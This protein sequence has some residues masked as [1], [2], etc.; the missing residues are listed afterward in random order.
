MAVKEILLLGNP[1]L[2]SKCETVKKMDH[3]VQSTLNDLKD[4]LNDFRSTHNFG[5]GIAALQIGLTKKIVFLQIDQPLVLINPEITGRSRQKMTLW[6]D[7]FSFPEI[8]V[9]VKRHTKITVK[10]TDEHGRRKILHAVGG[11]SELLQHEIDHL[12][13]ILAIDRAI[14]SKHIILKN[15]WKKLTHT[16]QDTFQL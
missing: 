1:I 8:V 7:C 6:D 10:Y 5:R 4:T 3:D 16:S 15:E 9:R 14:D 2:R 11:L 12:N 13:G